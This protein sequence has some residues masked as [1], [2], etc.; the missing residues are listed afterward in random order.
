MEQGWSW[1]S[2]P[3]YKPA[4]LLI[5]AFVFTAMV[6]MP[7]TQGMIDIVTKDNP[8][9]YKVPTDCKTIT[10]TVNKK[11]RPEAFAEAKGKTHSATHSKEGGH[12]AP[13]SLMT[14][15]EVAR[16]AK[17]TVDILFLAAFLW[18]TEAL[19]IGATD[20]MVGVMLYLFAVLPM[21]EISKAYMTDA[22]FFIL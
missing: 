2:R 15:M 14:E 12:D 17:I 9:G 13:K 10:D 7:P 22:V 16:L 8:P 21:N 3:G 11:L 18:G 6:I 5:A 4:L 19:S 1:K 20:I